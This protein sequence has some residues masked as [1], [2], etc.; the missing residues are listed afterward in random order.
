MTSE[1]DGHSER[2]T[3]GLSVDTSFEELEPFEPY[4]TD[5]LVDEFDTDRGIIRKLLDKLNR[6][7]K[8]K[9]NKPKSSPN[10]WIREPPVNGCS[11]CGREFEIKF[12][13]PPSR[14]CST[15]PGAATACE[16]VHSGPYALLGG[17]HTD[18]PNRK[19]ANSN[20][21]GDL[22]SRKS[23]GSRDTV[24]RAVVR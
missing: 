19:M 22:A 23:T 14:R 1:R 8:V 11:E 4:T 13:Y 2:D 16:R 21:S 3:T 6:E 15:V 12:L 5:E 18:G 17:T 24:R 7:E 20:L 10:L 9:K